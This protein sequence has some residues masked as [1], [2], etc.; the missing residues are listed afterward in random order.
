[1]TIMQT[2]HIGTDTFVGGVM[3][4]FNNALSIVQSILAVMQAMQTINSFLK[5]LPIPGLATGGTVPGTGNSDTVPAMLTPGEFVIK[6]SVV[7][8][9]G[10]QFFELI[11]GVEEMSEEEK[12]FSLVA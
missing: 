9:L 5:F 10:T 3:N 4:G 6:K 12:Y 8:K 11:N 2:L 7:N 1:M